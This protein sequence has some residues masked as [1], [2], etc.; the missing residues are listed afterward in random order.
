MKDLFGYIGVGLVAIALTWT[1]RGWVTPDPQI[2]RQV[3]SVYVNVPYQVEIIKERI[4]PN[5]VIRY[6]TRV[7]TVKD[8]RIERDTVYIETDSDIFMYDPSFLTQ[9]PT[10]PRFLGLDVSR[11]T[12]QLTA[13]RPNG[14]T[15]TSIWEYDS[16][17]D[18]I[19]RPDG[20]GWVG[21]D[22]KKRGRGGFSHYVE[23]GYLLGYSPYV[24][25]SPQIGVFGL[26]LAGK[27][28]LSKHSHVGG[29]LRINF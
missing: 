23:V 15:Q 12:L 10:T 5:T 24:E 13:Q 27:V 16:D 18:Y 19:L 21:I 2:I 20:D 26:Q 9:Y 25:Y 22:R 28:H 1:V 11:N 3:D 17:Y 29:G 6:K 8:V 14:T 7:D 4:I